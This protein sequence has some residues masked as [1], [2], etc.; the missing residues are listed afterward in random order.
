QK[1]E[2]DDSMYTVET[3]HLTKDIW[4][5]I[6][7]IY[8]EICPVRLVQFLRMNSILE[9][10]DYNE[11]YHLSNCS[12]RTEGWK[13]LVGDRITPPS[14]HGIEFCDVLASKGNTFY[15]LHVKHKFDGNAA[16]ALCSQVRASVKIL[17][18]SLV[19]ISKENMVE[20]FY[21]AV[22]GVN[23]DSEDHSKNSEH[24]KLSSLELKYIGSSKE[25]FLQTLLG[26]NTK[27]YVCLSPSIGSDCSFEAMR[28]CN[29]S[30]RFT[31][32]DFKSSRENPFKYIIKAGILNDNG[33]VMPQ[34]F[35]ITNPQD[36]TA[37]VK[38]NL[39]TE[40][41]DQLNKSLGDVRDT[42]KRKLNIKGSLLST[43]SFVTKNEFVELYSHF[44][45]ICHVHGSQDPIKLRI[46]E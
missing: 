11:L 28:E 24:K 16:R 33:R 40:E 6:S 8:P 19:G 30:Y 23:L 22:S 17:W 15:Y 29:L 5:K 32:D 44:T 10:G 31:K 21:D 9:E 35:N 18:D 4:R 26:N 3:P 34:L 13:Y 2:G 37:R 39:S 1:A 27:H 20:K 25:H 45:K 12:C 43:G 36:F 7:T 38:K 42:I 46:L 41:K 14:I